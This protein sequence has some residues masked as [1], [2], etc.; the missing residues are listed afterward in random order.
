MGRLV[1]I[2][3]SLYFFFLAIS[4]LGV[5]W[6]FEFPTAFP[7]GIDLATRAFFALLSVGLALG[8]WDGWRK[9]SL[10][11]ARN[12]RANWA[13]LAGCLSIAIAFV[14]EGLDLWSAHGANL[15]KES[16]N[17]LV[18]AAMGVV[19]ILAFRKSARPRE[20]SESNEAVVPS[21]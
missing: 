2:F 11:L 19:A 1:R 8:G 4:A 18:P 12:S 7:H 9:R 6:L 15:W 3:C 5:A 17:N 10:V 16:R 13:L 20:T 21:P 14:A